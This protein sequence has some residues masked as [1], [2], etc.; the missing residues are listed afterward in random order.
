MNSRSVRT[1]MA[2]AAA[3]SDRHL[4]RTGRVRLT[5]DRLAWHTHRDICDL[6]APHRG[7][8]CGC[9][10]R[11]CTWQEAYSTHCSFAYLVNEDRED[12]A[13]HMRRSDREHRAS[14]LAGQAQDA[15]QL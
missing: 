13:M 10:P 3:A 5:A 14:D 2:A 6:G 4:G 12:D 8:G 9:G 1:G 7:Y 11:R 15:R